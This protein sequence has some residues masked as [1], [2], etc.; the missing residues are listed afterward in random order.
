[1]PISDP[2]LRY[3]TFTQ[4]VDGVETDFE[5]SFIGGYINPAHVKAFSVIVDA[6]TGLATDRQVHATEIVA[7]DGASSTVRVAPAVADGRT[8]VIYRDTTKLSMLVNYSDGTVLT[9]ANLDLAN[10]QLLML[11]QE[12]LDNV[13]GQS[14]S[15]E[16]AVSTVIDLTTIVNEIYT[17]VLELLA[18]GG[19]V[20]V[21]PRVWSGVGDGE[22]AEFE[23]PGADVEGAGF[24]DTYL[25]GAGLHPSEDYTVNVLDPVTTSRLV[26]TVPPAVGVAWFTVLRGYA[27]PYTGV[28]PVTS[29]RIPVIEVPGTSYFAGFESEFA[30]LDCTNA[31][32]VTINVKEIPSGGDAASKLGTG[33]Y[34][35]A[36]QSGAG[37]VTFAPENVEV[38]LVVPAGLEPKT[39]AEGSIIT[40]TCKYGDGNT[41]IVSGDLALAE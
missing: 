35:S 4:E 26:F 32:P 18:A 13:S 28:Q 15:V 20:S 40:A 22:T 2:N 25:N 21:E 38:T 23:I 34:Y 8:L 7:T 10:R 12:L 1:M 3:A 37:Q 36:V 14:L 5:V 41:W 9:K 30:L 24:Y 6:E 27:K 33:S 39:R 31:S 17:D 29:L 16:D 11:V 19:I